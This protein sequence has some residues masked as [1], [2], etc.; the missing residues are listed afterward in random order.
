MRHV[1]FPL[2]ALVGLALAITSCVATA[3]PD[4]PA[5]TVITEDTAP[6]SGSTAEPATTITLAQQDASSTT[7]L[8]EPP[9]EEPAFPRFEPGSCKV[10]GLKELAASPEYTIECGSVIVLEDRGDPGGLAVALP[11]AIARTRNETPM[12]DPVIYLAGGGGH[13]HLT[14][15]HYLIKS[16]GDAVLADRDFIQYNQRGAPGTDPELVC[17]GYTTFLFSLASRPE[18]DSMWTAEHSDYLTDCESALIDSGIDVTQ[19]N[20]VTNAADA[21]DIAIALGYE[22]ANYYG[23]SY[24]T[25][26]GLDLI[27]DYP[28]G[29]RSII[30]DS[31]YPPEVGY[32][33]EY[34]RSLDRA[35]NAVFD[36]CSTDLD[37]D[38]RFPN[39]EADFY[40]SVDRLNVEPQMVESPFG[41]VSVDGGVFMD[42]MSIYL[43][44][45]EW[46]V[47]APKAMD[48]VAQGQLGSVERVVVGAITTPDLNWSMF[49]AMQ[50]REEVPFEDWDHAISLGADLPDQVVAHYTE[51]FARFH[52]EMCETSESGTALVVESEAVL[53]D[54]PALV[55]A[56]GYDPATPPYWSESA[57]ATLGNAV[58]V[59]FPTL[60]HGI[61][62]SNSCGLSI[63]LAFIDDPTGSPDT[64]CVDQLPPVAF[65]I[66]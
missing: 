31:V 49:Y 29:V 51:G 18:L 55:L 37:C 9:L 33:T 65:D 45:P 39:L 41:P 46:I 47:R 6:S 15:A 44:S 54:V 20:S 22:Q 30:L 60:G 59:E 2:T 7:L 19:Y 17:P 34:A 26:L 61:M 63:G 58:Y 43:Y 64:T 14:Y 8:E 62:R 40:A 10:E 24:G 5:D 35:F 52:F 27:R 11:V 28:D 16:V 32:Y 48:D 3:E 36:G 42:A 53:S 21:A 23:T 66:E 38:A 50:C 57:A 25:R 56:G 13:A 4:E 1:R 12:S